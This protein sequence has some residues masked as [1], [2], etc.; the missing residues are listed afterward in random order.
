LSIQDGDST[1][2][3][4][5]LRFKEGIRPEDLR[6]QRKGTELAI[7][8]GASGSDRIFIGNYFPY[9]G[10]T[11]SARIER[12]VFADG[13]E[14]SFQDVD[15]LAEVPLATTE[16][17]N[18]VYGSGRDETILGLGGDDVIDGYSGDDVLDGGT[19]IDQ[20]Y[21]G[22]GDDTLTG[23]INNQSDQE[24]ERTWNFIGDSWGGAADKLYGGYGNDTYIFN[25]G[26]GYDEVIDTGG[27]D[28]VVFGPGIDVENIVVSY[29]SGWGHSGA[30]RIG[31][32]TGVEDEGA[33]FIRNGA[34]ST[35]IERFESADGTTVLASE[36]ANYTLRSVWGTS[37]D[38][39]IREGAGPQSIYADSGN[40]VVH[41]G[42]GR[43]TL[44]GGYGNDALFGDSGNDSLV[45]EYGDNYLDGGAGNDT[46]SGRGYLSGGEG[47]DFLSGSGVLDGG[48]GNDR[49]QVSGGNRSTVV[50]G[51][52]YGSDVLLYP[53]PGFTVQLKPGIRPEDVE[54]LGGYIEGEGGTLTLA[55]RGS[56]DRLAGVEL[57][58]AVRFAD[59]SAWTLADMLGRAI[60]VGGTG[61]DDRLAGTAGNDAIDGGAGDDRVSGGDGDDVLAGGEGND[62]L[63]GGI[64]DDH[65]AGGAGS[66][67]LYGGAGQDAYRLESGMGLDVVH[68][69]DDAAA[70][71]G[72][73]TIVEV[74]AGVDKDA[75]VISSAWNDLRIGIAGSNDLLALSGWLSRDSGTGGLEIRFADGTVWD[76]R[77]VLSR[78][79]M[80]DATDGND[81]L[82][83]DC[84][85]NVLDGGAGGDG[86]Y[87]EAGDD[88]LYGGAGED[89]LE[90]GEGNDLLDGGEDDDLL[91]GG[92]GD[93]VLD[94][95]AGND[96]LRG[97]AGADV[98]RFG[99]GS[100]KDTISFDY[101]GGAPADQ[102]DVIQMGA[103]IGASDVGFSFSNGDLVISV[104][105][106][107]DTLTIA[108][109]Q[110]DEIRIERIRF[111][112][113]T[114]YS[115][116]A[117]PEGPLLATE[118][119]DNITASTASPYNDYLY[120]LGGND[121][122]D[123]GAGD[124][125]I[126]G[127]AGNDTLTGGAGA[128][129]LDGGPGYD[130]YYL[131]TD[132]QQSDEIVFGFD[133]GYDFI[134][135]TDYHASGIT[136]KAV[137]FESNVTPDDVKI[138]WMSFWRPST[139]SGIPS[140]AF[141]GTM[142]ITL[143]GSGAH[144]DY[145]QL[146][147]DADSGA[148]TLAT[149]FIFA[150]GTVWDGAE[151]L[152]RLR[153][154]EGT[155]ISDQLI[156]TDAGDNLS[157]LAGND[158]LVGGSG[159]DTL[160][161]GTGA[162]SLYGGADDDVLLGGSE[163]DILV[164]GAGNDVLDGGAGNDTLLG[165]AGRNVF[166]FGANFGSDTIYLSGGEV[167]PQIVEF[168]ASVSPGALKV[169]IAGGQLT[170]EIGGTQNRVQISNGAI[171]DSTNEQGQRLAVGEVRFADGTVWSEADLLA[172][173]TVA[174]AG[175]DTL[176]GSASDDGIQGLAGNDQLTGGLGNDRLY[177][178]DGDDTLNGNAGEDRLDGGAG[179][180]SL[181]GGMGN[182]TYRFGPGAGQDV[183]LDVD[184]T[185]GNV[186]TILMSGV[187]PGDVE[188][189]RS[190]DGMVLS[191]VGT[192]DRLTV[193]NSADGVVGVERVRF[194]NGTVMDLATWT[195]RQDEVTFALGQGD[196]VFAEGMVRDTL[197]FA[198]GISA[199]EISVS[200][201]GDDLLF[202]HANGADSLRIEGWY[203][204]PTSS[205]LLQAR[206]GDTLWSA[207]DLSRLGLAGGGTE[208]DDILRAPAALSVSLDGLGGN[209]WLYGGEEADVIAGGSG[210]DFLD[211]GLGA[212]RLV[213]GSGDD[214]Y[215]VDTADDVINEEAGGGADTVYAP[216][217]ITL[218]PALENLVLLG[219]G[220]LDGTGNDADN[221][222]VGN[223]AVNT[224]SG[225]LGNDVLDGGAGADRLIGGLGDDTYYLDN[226]AD[227]PVENA[228]EGND[229]I[230]SSFS[231][232]LGANFEN[233]SLLGG[234]SLNGTGNAAD[235]RLVGNASS[236][237]LE[238]LAGNDFLDGGAGVDVLRGGAGNDTY[239]V[240]DVAD[241]VIESAGN[242][243]DTVL[244][245]TS[246]V[247]SA[248]VE[249]LTLE[250][251]AAINGTGNALGNQ[252]VGNSGANVLVGNGGDD[253]LDGKAGNDILHGGQGADTYRFG[254]GAGQ[255]VVVETGDTTGTVDRI[256]LQEGVTADDLILR[257]NGND[258]I[259]SQR[260]ST[261]RITVRN[262]KQ[263][264]GAIEEIR[265]HDGSSFGLAQ[266]IALAD[267]AGA[268]A[269]PQLAVPLLDSAGF[270]GKPFEF[271]V[272]EGSFADPD[273]GDAL[274]YAATLA[275]G[276]PL[277]TWLVFDQ[278]ARR[279]VGTPAVGDVGVYAVKVIVSDSGN[280]LASEAFNLTVT[281]KHDTS[282]ILLHPA[283][284]AAVTQHHA[285][286]LALPSD[287]F[288]DQDPGDTLTYTARLSD[289]QPLPSWLVFDPVER[290]FAGTPPSSVT[291]DLA[292]TVTATDSRGRMASDA[293]LLAVGDENDAPKVVRLT[294]DLLLRQGEMVSVQ[295]AADAFAD[296][297]S[298]TLTY[299]ATLADGD[300][301]P[302]WLSFDPIARTLSGQPEGEQVGV[303]T[304]KVTATDT[305]GLS[306]SDTFNIAVA[307][308][309][310]APVV[311]NPLADMVAREA[312][313]F[314]FVL[315]G[316]AFADAD[317]GDALT[318]SFRIL[319]TPAH[320]RSTFG[321][322]SVT[323]EIYRTSYSYDGPTRLD[324]WDI[325]TWRFEV[326]ATDRM[327][328]K[329]SDIFNLT[330]DPAG[331]NHRPV[332]AA[333][334]SLWNEAKNFSQKKIIQSGAGETSVPLTTPEAQLPGYAGVH[335]TDVDSGDVLQYSLSFQFASDASGTNYPLGSV[336]WSF[337]PDTGGLS[338]DI[339]AG[340]RVLNWQVTATDAGG[341]SA[342]YSYQLLVNNDPEAQAIPDFTVREDESFSFALPENEFVDP[343]GD[344][345]TFSE[346]RL[347]T[348]ENGAWRTWAAYDPL[349]N[350]FSGKAGDFNVGRHYVRIGVKDIYGGNI[351]GNN[352]EL[353]YTGFYLNVTNTYDPPR[354]VGTLQD[355]E[356]TEDQAVYIQTSQVFQEVDGGEVLTYG[357]SLS[358]GDPLP[359]WLSINPATGE[360]SGT[361]HMADVGSMSVTVTTSD[362]FGANVSDTFDLT[363]RL[364]D[365]NHAPVLAAPLP[366]QVYRKEQ[367]FTFQLAPGSFSDVDT[368][369]SLT[370][371]AMLENGQPL[372][373]WVS[374][375][376]NTLT[377]SGT[378]PV[379]QLTPTPIMV[380]AR[381]SK[382]LETADV[383]SIAVDVA[384]QPPVVAKPLAA[385]M[386]AED[387]AFMLT[388]PADAFVDNDSGE[389]LALS[390][391]LAD[392]SPLPAW[393]IF[394]PATGMFSGTPGNSDVGMLQ[395]MLTATDVQGGST[396]D[397]FQLTVENVNDAPVPVQALTNHVAL[398]DGLMSF[399]LP[400]DAF[401]DIDAGDVLT[402]SATLSDGQ[403]LPSW[404]A[405]D[406]STG[407]FSGVPDDA[408]VG[409]MDML[410]TATDMAGASASQV[411]S[412]TVENVND[413][414]FLAHLID[415]QS[416]S[417][418]LPFV[419][420]VPADVFAD[421]DAG[422]HLA[423]S[424]TLADGMPLPAWLAFDPVSGVFTGTPAN[425]D[426]GAIV[427]KVA[428]TDMAGAAVSQFFE[429]A[430]ANVN[431]APTVAMAPADQTT[432]ENQLFSLA[433]PAGTFNDVD[434]IHGDTLS[435]SA[436]L[437]DGGAL[438][439]WLTFDAA[440][441]T[442]IGTPANG[443]VGDLNV[444]VTATDTG[445]LSASSAFSL[446]V[447]NVNDAPAA[448]ADTANATE[449]GGAVLLDAATLLANDTDPDLIHGDA[450]NIT[451]VSQA[452][453]GA[454]VSLTGGAVQYDPGTLFQSLA[455]GQTATDTFSY[456]VSDMA[457]A[458]STATVTLTVTGV[459]DGP[460]AA[461][462]AA[463]VQEDL[464]LVAAGNVLTNDSDADQGTVLNVA[465]AGTLQGS[466]GSLI[467]NAD[468][469]YT[470]QLDNAGAAVQG[471]MAGQS[472]IDS[473]GYT[474]TDSAGAV[475]GAMVNLTVTGVNDGPQANGD[476][477]ATD[478]DIAQTI[479]TA[480]SLLA[481]DTD[482][483]T[484]DVISITAFDAVTALGNTVGMDAA[485]NLIFDIGDR[486][487]SL[488]Q[489]ETITDTFGYTVTDT[490]GA[491]STAQISMSISGVNDAPVAA[492]DTAYVQEDLAPASGNVLANDSDVDQ[493]TLLTVADA[494]T[495]QG[496]YGQLAL[497]ADGSYSYTLD[498][499]ST[500][501][502]QAVQSL[503]RNA[504]VA[505]HF[506][507]TA[508]DGIAGASAVLDVFISGAND[509]PILAAPLADRDIVFNKA[510]SWQL[511]E[512]SFTDIDAGDTLTYG[513][514]QA[515][516]TALPDWLVFDA[517]TR[518]F[519]GQ[520]PKQA[521]SVDVMVTATDAAAGG[522]TEGSLA[523][524]DVFRVSVSHGNEGMGN[525]EDAPPPG[526]HCNQ[527]DGS[528]TSPGHPDS[529]DGNGHHSSGEDEHGRDDDHD[530]RR[531]DSNSHGDGDADSR[532][533]EE[534]IR[535]WFEQ[536]SRDER[537]A[538]FGATGR[539]GGGSSQTDWQVKRNVAEGISGDYRTE[540]ARMD[541]QL[542]E[543]LAQAGGDSF[544]EF[545]TDTRPPGLFGSGGSQSL[546]QP[547]M[548]T[549]QQM[550][551]FAGLG[552]GLVRLGC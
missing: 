350:T 148:P 516:G 76:E 115:L 381:D 366:D 245:T 543:H 319:E 159:A 71:D 241:Q 111:D 445:G 547:G 98:Y 229:T 523:A 163:A 382:G 167:V 243:S 371:R 171:W 443:D 134:Y 123:G 501:S 196:V 80:I 191:I 21:G 503:N 507:Y 534:L 218:A 441:Q 486:Y 372:P 28:R 352:G 166:R 472:V 214:T 440:T 43:D 323:K 29:N 138:D 471:L 3:G 388:V 86:V 182:D 15:R 19:G 476:S 53:Q 188:V 176:M 489:G 33:V 197:V 297:E 283:L 278:A 120:A 127:G 349:T 341:L 419:F 520:A 365:K 198:D 334:V 23:G 85:A 190:E 404:L 64:G 131:S 129:V 473:F 105:S 455:Q 17:N 12:F 532:R 390:A 360:L 125:H 451:G 94:G 18:V 275:D 227:T 469:S 38:D 535:S 273:V 439:A 294:P 135:P 492:A 236:N 530:D 157:G 510:F 165:G 205:L 170:L 270:V 347:Q 153:R 142:G 79:M 266:I 288:F 411:F 462:D 432:V 119:S 536:E 259:V 9:L 184:A 40:D 289:G 417:E 483:D 48:A 13:S 144:L 112:D 247:L 405:F 373:T 219:G 497:A 346:G 544:A 169:T 538:P 509:A 162:D 338:Y 423:L 56:G 31:Y 132:D 485:G 403:M 117:R 465:N 391:V 101:Y 363:V 396:S 34:S 408:E 434:F 515:D 223:S 428:A 73:L 164:G 460:V 325:G 177:G 353:G 494:G 66:D 242:G 311:A 517:A 264:G 65:L 235:N 279:F 484:G 82:I 126:F 525:G 277:P 109:W 140:E 255:D 496:S 108:N 203:R 312:E 467:L 201:V 529:N 141:V 68:E 447:A 174:T 253:V 213:G 70:R 298:D 519:S 124:D 531:G 426:V 192:T 518:T 204:H 457:G 276:S 187:L 291:G 296:P 136:P 314:R 216:F 200:A 137:R 156:G 228:G 513:A 444:L 328:L 336:Q 271:V 88:T 202:T 25:A 133:S 340:P 466:Y 95:G 104:G 415:N 355:L 107:E 463:A 89:T 186:D 442:F 147:M 100:G 280:L 511:P 193:R 481:N 308:V 102:L 121:Y 333:G 145:L 225:G 379:G 244:S 458:T 90:G 212:D 508:T 194:D 468:G 433:I 250:G 505:E 414:P 60:P 399:V 550:K 81:V 488:A 421:A 93:D 128:D 11:A 337:N 329:T 222:L 367:T 239:R 394:D 406:A 493:G 152:E 348:Y 470:Y 300:P 249:N 422:D 183:I 437:A 374:F 317:R 55:L 322:N 392:G 292:I 342:S 293:F 384:N 402:L 364:A 500:G 398:E 234:A 208:G 257:W 456:T 504:Q 412:L 524:S 326:T 155:S 358:N 435:Y 299:T 45:D 59:G 67:N 57:A 69:A 16:G 537:H 413:A 41:G 416:A 4:D 20:L 477:A 407:T 284:D 521:G 389:S 287:M 487:Q 548:G 282:P 27:D 380:A 44:N 54:V 385:Q 83:G 267:G 429:I 36:L 527:N 461:D 449:D 209:D 495:R 542:K 22:D 533:T 113:G 354:L 46:L 199:G 309:N 274:A 207:V 383:F 305:S 272:P 8:V 91:M 332:I 74:A 361:P 369:D 146:G 263:A 490:A 526:H 499:P 540:W 78:R 24:K 551:G 370:Y 150:D 306:A 50:F 168:D 335:F 307:D 344:L 154:K 230:Y 482:P 318:Y 181:S 321:F 464:T 251:D 450:L 58:G 397:V 233:L 160:D 75:L 206:L 368:G 87:G 231:Y 260:D 172:H 63:R 51:L 436:T 211:G 232:T 377:F 302:G 256:L 116:L 362:R 313:D 480:A 304:I 285:F 269:A 37:G 96:D 286:T 452:A 549:S 173:A 92:A 459:N 35:P 14:L 61:A 143:K 252:L 453:S 42:A 262:F 238:G 401:G 290:L 49:I 179:N 400:T 240:D 221:R 158:T 114:E 478:E 356:K 376:P 331:I 185:P 409:T 316:G 189:L 5:V 226:A 454:A 103:G 420:Q 541:A 425:K 545:G 26:S 7:E 427:V 97:G 39:V 357:A 106:G 339:P 175:A 448:N 254:F 324:Y 130:N 303:T 393:L 248:E 343:D 110:F 1:S 418:D 512:G 258:L 77:E 424:A 351:H 265:F 149:S 281:H 502:G 195:P 359:S 528:G 479:L 498:N 375:D 47:D 118:G 6:Y 62:T 378:L 10:Q 446:N 161:G 514:T 246:F 30:A 522:S 139:Y 552:E 310:D 215:V 151:I 345:L 438:P 84:Y 32:S 330:V 261:D 52:G 475:S 327:G 210:N 237:V 315:P 539:N 99:L 268:D 387:S 430:V 546:T 72:A 491:T 431:D 178:G 301:L 474:M 320:A 224:L 506:G 2:A 122:V 217:S 220:A 395:V 180:D 386:A 410:V 295:L